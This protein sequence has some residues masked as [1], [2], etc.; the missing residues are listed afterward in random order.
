METSKDYTPR[1]YRFLYVMFILL[2]IYQVAMNSDFIQGASSFG[3]ALIF[4]PFNHQVTWSD[5]PSWQRLWLYV[6]LGIAA[7]VLGYGFAV[8]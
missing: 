2:G 3:I 6:H 8:T 1:F 5:R 7:A 4:D